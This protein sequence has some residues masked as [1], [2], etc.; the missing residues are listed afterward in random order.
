MAAS[1]DDRKTHLRQDRVQ[2]ESP[3]PLSEWVAA[4]V[5]LVLLVASVGY[6]LHDGLTAPEQA[7]SPVIQVLA[8]EPDG[9][10]FLVRLRVR[11]QS[12]STAAGLRVEGELKQGGQVVERSE[13]EFEHV[14]GHSEREGGMF[15]SR[16][17]RRL[18]LVLTARSY[19]KP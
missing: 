6:L 10:R 9:D 1:T 8:L 19:R 17:P 7:P 5:G 16:D 13:T 18:E 12:G 3:P 2:S 11:N 4:A 15:F 14:P